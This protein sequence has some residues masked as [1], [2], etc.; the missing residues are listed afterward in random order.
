MKQ[1][2]TNLKQGQVFTPT[3]VANEM[4][5]MISEEDFSSLESFFF[6]PT[7]GNGAILVPI[8]E[9]CY[10]ALLTKRY[11]D[12]PA[13]ALSQALQKVYAIELDPKLVIEARH[14][15]FDW[16]CSKLTSQPT[17]LELSLIG[18]QIAQSIECR[19][20]FDVM[21]NTVASSAGTRALSR[22]ARRVKAGDT[23]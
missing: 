23:K 18:C 3:K 7:C 16:V 17:E 10:T 5:D 11:P 4:L 19:D 8:L 2:K 12:S 20:F 15:V 21:D 9:R 13:M 6:E 22:K 1:D 14:A